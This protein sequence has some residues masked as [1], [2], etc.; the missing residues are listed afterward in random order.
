MRA[1]SVVVLIA[2]SVL[3]FEPVM[4]AQRDA[5]ALGSSPSAPSG[6]VPLVPLMPRAWDDASML[7]AAEDSRPRARSSRDDG[8]RRRADPV[9]TPDAPRAPSPLDRVRDRNDATPPLPIVAAPMPKRERQRQERR[10]QLRES[11]DGEFAENER[12]IEK[13]RLSGVLR[14]R[15]QAFDAEVRKRRDAA[16]SRDEGEGGPPH[17]KLD[18][19]RLP[20]RA[21]SKKIRAPLESPQLIRSALF[22]DYAPR[23][24]LQPLAQL[25]QAGAAPIVIAQAGPLDPPTAADLAPTEDAPITP[26]ITALAEQ[27]GRSPVLIY[28][29]VRNNIRFQPTY[30]SIQGA[31]LTLANRRGNAFDTASLLVALLR[32]ANVPARY[33]YGTVEVPADQVRNWIGGAKSAEMAQDLL[34]QGGIPN[35]GVAGAG[36]VSS[37]RLEHVWVEAFVDWTPSRGAVNRNPDT[38]VPIDPSFKL[39]QL[40]PGIDLRAGAPLN[41]DQVINQ[42]QSAALNGPEGSVTGMDLAQWE[43]AID[44]HLPAARAYINAQKPGATL[45]DLAGTSTLIALNSPIL[46]GTHPYRV[47]ATGA[48]F[49]AIPANLRHTLALKLY[50]SESDR[51]NDSPQTTY[52]ISL[53]RL[54][55]QALGVTYAPATPDDAQALQSYRTEGASSLPLYLLKVVPQVQLEGAT[56]AS[57][58]AVTMGQAQFW[59]AQLID[60]NDQNNA[61][62]WFNTTAGDE[63]I[64][65]V[66][67]AGVTPQMVQARIDRKAAPTAREN[68]HQTALHFWMEHDFFDELEAAGWGV[69]RTRLPSVGVFA[70]PLTI[71]YFLGIPKRGWYDSRR[72]DVSRNLQAAVGEDQKAVVGFFTA[73]GA[74]GSYL[75][76]SILKQ[77]FRDN[78]NTPLSTA[79]ILL[80]ANEQRI[81]IYSID[82]GNLASILP[83]LQLD[84]FVEADIANA[85]AA[86]KVVTIPER[87]IASAGW[88]GTGYIVQDPAT[89]AAAYLID[90]G[91][92]GGLQT[93]CDASLNP[94]DGLFD[95]LLAEIMDRLLATL[96]D[97]A[98]KRALVMVGGK[99]IPAQYAIVSNIAF[100]MIAFRLATIEFTLATLDLPDSLNQLASACQAKNLG[101]PESSSGLCR[102]G[103]KRGGRAGPITGSRPIHYATGNK[104]RIEP[105][106]AGTGPFP[107]EI[108]RTYNSLSTANGVWGRGW[109]A[110][111]DRALSVGGGA[112]NAPPTSV[113]AFRP[114]GKY[115]RFANRGA[116]GYAPDEDVYDRLVREAD[117]GWRYSNTLDEVERYDPTGRLVS[118][119]NRAGLTQTLAYNT[120]GQ[121]AQVTDPFGRTLAFEYNSAGQIRQ[122]TDPSG[123]LFTYQYDAY[124]NLASV[125]YPE[126][127][128]RTY[129]YENARFPNF[130]TGITDERGI[131]HLTFAYDSQGRAM[132]SKFADDQDPESVVYNT[133]GTT[134]VTDGLGTARIFNFQR[135]LERPL[136]GATT[137]PCPSCGANDSASLTYNARGSVANRTDFNGNQ[138]AYNHDVRG[139]EAS[140]TEAAGTP[141]A[142]TI[143]TEWHP[144]FALPVRISEPT[145]AG[146]RI[147]TF[148]HDPRGNVLTRSVAVGGQT[149]TWA[150]TYN[151]N[152]QPLTARGPRTDVDDTTTWTYDA[153]GNVATMTNALGQITRYTAHDADGRPL[154]MSDANGLVTTMS[155]D[156]RGRLLASTAGG[157][158]T[159]YEYDNA[160]NLT[161][162]T[163]PDASALLYTYDLGQRLTSIAD[164]LGNRIAYT[165][166]RL[167]N[168]I[169]EESR[170]PTGTLAQSQTRIFDALSRLSAEVGAQN[171]RTV[172][173]YDAQGNL[174]GSADPLQQATSQGFDALNR[175]T[176]ITDPAAGVTE[177]AYDA[178]DNL[179][180]V[181]DPRGLATRYTYNGFDELASLQS[182]DTG[183]TS[184]AYD[185][186]GNLRTSTDARGR[187]ATYAY[188]TLNRVTQV[189]YSDET[190]AYAYDDT[191][192]GNAGIGRLTRLTDASGTT[193]YRYDLQGRVVEKTQQL[194]PGTAALTKRV[195][196]SYNAVGQLSAMTTPSGQVVAIAY[197]ADGRIREL[198]V[199][200][201]LIASEIGYFPFGEPKS[202]R[203]GNGAAYARSFDTDG[204]I[205]EVA[206]PGSART[207]SFDAASRITGIGEGTFT[208]SFG[209]DT[210]DRLTSALIPATTLAWTYDALGNRLSETRNAASTPYTYSSTSNRL[211]SIGATPI[212]FDAAGNISADGTRTYTYSSRNRLTRVNQGSAS[213]AYTLNGFGERVLKSV[214]GSGNPADS[215]QFVYDED[216][217]LLGE[218]DALG[219]LIAEHLWLEDTPVAVFKP[220]NEGYGGTA[221]GAAE[222]F[223][224]W[225]DHLDTPRRITNAANQVVWRWDS[226]PFGNGAAAEDP[227]SLGRNFKHHLRFPGQYLDVEMGLH[228][229]YFRDY[230]PRT[231]RYVQSDPIGLEAGTNTFT[232]VF[233]SPLGYVDEDGLRVQVNKKR[234]DRYRDKLACYFETQGWQVRKEVYV[235]VPGFKRGRY[236]DII[237]SKDGR[238]V[239]IE[240][241]TG[242]SRYGKVQRAKD[243][244]LKQRGTP[245]I[246][247]RKC[248]GCS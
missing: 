221:A 239:I 37:I 106:Y 207:Y 187:T 215:T 156:G 64:V 212:T 193:R 52:T 145:T 32:A 219:N 152:G 218:Y 224:V 71:R 40:Q 66:N 93:G 85:V 20:W 130:L 124:G 163:L 228:Y 25:A 53:P 198:R 135:V 23:G 157:E 1:T 46:L 16:G 234:G 108:T 123:R 33:V 72:L 97:T 49:A 69:M 190:L 185:A 210:L 24:P 17:L 137:Q 54:G 103:G 101:H 139:L 6:T 96:T 68:L 51:A 58:A 19:A 142:R 94:L 192:G 99:L 65:G 148:T 90:G 14:T 206:L 209:Y 70:S 105:D 166:D 62:A 89:G 168:R 171:Q 134:T 74:A 61:P 170:D 107:L 22:R 175:L 121:L 211:A 138:T 78:P 116:Q 120:V 125:G 100:F 177:Y 231:G 55:M 39:Q 43:A 63:V 98:L 133:D 92:N 34:G 172:Y 159:G 230:D 197:A 181:T 162:L 242:E 182:P 15:Q 41:G 118:I 73:S 247:F 232:Y 165:L 128:T 188:D 194:A 160:G 9:T 184:N 27:L 102:P 149:R 48:R 35:V 21:P 82:A 11:L 237:C 42:I 83:R 13:H 161:R 76:G 28:N 180:R 2:F 226:D 12:H 164:T 186:A 183:T 127:G 56:V 205:A 158:R 199:N 81:P 217:R 67:G 26:A 244:I 141:Q 178:Q 7:A 140:R 150:W 44:A 202:W 191:A 57:G 213:F 147:T 235:P 179:T 136:T 167:G 241:K 80:L 155:Y 204:R 195:A 203:L 132:L 91:I 112:L 114:D 86:G 227:S 214:V 248:R 151:T 119:T 174:T 84:P 169:A 201:Q 60:P 31:E 18:P 173:G 223:Y 75:E 3:S 79:R 126:S 225:A 143:T 236:C 131:R 110:S 88:T 240:V 59:N 216:G 238:R 222:V 208:S 5:A 200:G 47:V 77:L 117:G 153:Q 243:A 233:G 122:M 111:Y 104:F 229:N 220:A 95:V 246:V 189:T 8:I 29:W 50:A 245:V 196:Y 113:T 4:A 87:E 144:T 45:A 115:F 36:S 10:A 129:H 30:G 109:R 146:T 154:S 38:W 176:R